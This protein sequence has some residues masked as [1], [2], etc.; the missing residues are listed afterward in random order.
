MKKVALVLLALAL[1]ALVR[2]PTVAH[3]DWMPLD[4]NSPLHTLVANDLA[5]GGHPFRIVS[6]GA[7]EGLRVRLLAMPLMLVAAFLNLFTSPAAAMN[8]AVWLWVAATGVVFAALCKRLGGSPW[9]GL[10]VLIGA[11]PCVQALGNG[12]YENIAYAGHALALV[13]VMRRK[14]WEVALAGLLVGLSSPYQGVALG[15]LLI[16]LGLFLRQWKAPAAGFVG[17]VVA[18]IY[19]AG[20]LTGGLDPTT[21]MPAPALGDQGI[22]VGEL[23][24]GGQWSNSASAGARSW[25]LLHPEPAR[26]L[27]MTWPWVVSKNE[28]MLGFALV[29]F[30]VWGL[31]KER[32]RPVAKA[33]ALAAATCVVIA[34]GHRLKLTPS[35]HTVIPLPWL[36]SL[37]LPG[38]GEM[39]ATA[40]FLAMAVFALGVGSAWALR[41]RW[42]LLAPLV[43]VEG[44]WFSAAHWPAP[45]LAMKLPDVPIAEEGPVAVWP[46]P[47]ALMPRYH[48]LASIA[49]DR[50]V[51]WF[52]AEPR[53]DAPLPGEGP[54][55]TQAVAETDRFGRTPE[56][57]LTW[58]GAQTM[59]EIQ[60][61][62][63]P[64]SDRDLDL[65]EGV[66]EAAVCVWTTEA[67]GT[68]HP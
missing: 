13:G 1:A 64:L 9:V 36:A 46:G 18:A 19:F 14:P 29:G 55:R 66:C 59:L 62:F 8:L 7:P 40:R 49:L 41:G 3:P 38:I 65:G 27:G 12:Q 42:M 48:C 56:Q 54:V 15:L 24:L 28:G 37:W 25:A 57:W 44:L 45:V 67:A 53:D 17:L 10:V 35:V 5:S 2:W 4:P 51:A 30:G 32:A 16:S 60:G 61:T 43:V 11:P 52:Q 63:D 6:L 58:S 33:L 39:Q 68:A 21:A 50:P 31:W 47:P 26:E 22:T 34:L 20:I 23:F